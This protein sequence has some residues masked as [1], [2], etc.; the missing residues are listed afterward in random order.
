MQRIFKTTCEVTKIARASLRE[1][2]PGCQMGNATL[3]FAQRGSGDFC[4][5][6]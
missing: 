1:Q 2:Q 5:N 4:E 3:L 6:D